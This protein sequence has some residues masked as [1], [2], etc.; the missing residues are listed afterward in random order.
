MPSRRSNRHGDHACQ[1]SFRFVTASNAG[2]SDPRELSPRGLFGGDAPSPPSNATWS[3]GSSGAILRMTKARADWLGGTCPTISFEKRHGGP[4]RYGEAMRYEYTEKY[5]RVG[6]KGW[7]E[8]GGALLDLPSEGWELFM[9][10][11]VTSLTWVLP[12]ICGSRTTAI[13]HYFRRPL[14][15]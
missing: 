6:K 12:G 3:D 11:P 4:V 2:S 13:I 1:T 7:R 10:V 9:A 15:S 8:L 14:S 5:I